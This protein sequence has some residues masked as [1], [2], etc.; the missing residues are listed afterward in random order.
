MCDHSETATTN[1][2]DGFICPITHAVMKEPLM[3]KEGFCFER[4]AILEWV[5]ANGTC[6]LTRQPLSSTQLV[7]NHALKNRIQNWYRLQNNKN[8]SFESLVDYG[9]AV[10]TTS[11][12]ASS[13]HLMNIRRMV[14]LARQNINPQMADL[15]CM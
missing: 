1:I 8:E 9:V 3:T 6:P 14:T 13:V 5:L 12:G 7:P 15:A 10:S 4:K 2:P 11:S